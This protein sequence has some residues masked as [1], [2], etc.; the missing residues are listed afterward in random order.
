MKKVDFDWIYPYKH[1][2]RGS[3]IPKFDPQSN[4]L[5]ISDGWGANISGMRLRR[6]SL[7]NGQEEISVVVRDGVCS[8]L[9]SENGKS[10]FVAL[11]RRLLELNRSDLSIKTSWR[12]HVPRSSFFI[13]EWR[14][15]LLLMNWSGPTFSLYDLQTSTVKRK[16]LGS[17]SGLFP[18]DEDEFLVASGL[19][20][21]VWKLSMNDLKV[22][23]WLKIPQFQS[24][25]YNSPKQLLITAHGKHHTVTENSLKFHEPEKRVSI[26]DLSSDNKTIEYKVPFKYSRLSYKPQSQ[27][28]YFI[29]KSRVQ[30]FE[31]TDDKLKKMETWKVDNSYDI[32]DFV[33][34]HDLVIA[35]KNKGMQS[36]LA[37][38][39]LN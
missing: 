12:K 16:K 31:I 24:V 10:I 34:D 13:S 30:S 22:C 36:F 39:R 8:L 15:H 37:I 9:F 17:C 4:T 7:A 27:L 14:K 11:S 32:I 33:P 25:I 19:E 1:S 6:I 3:I 35:I 26:T 29:H 28:L 23:P 38:A 21:I 5:L 18:L 2:F 20:G